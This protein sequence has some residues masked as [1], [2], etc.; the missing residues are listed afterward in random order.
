MAANSYVIQPPQEKPSNRQPKVV[1][2]MIGIN[3]CNSAYIR[4]IRFKFRVVCIRTG[5]ILM[6]IF[7]LVGSVLHHACAGSHQL[8]FKR[9]GLPSFISDFYLCDKACHYQAG[10][11][12]ELNLCHF[13]ASI[14][15]KPTD[16]NALFAIM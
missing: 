7:F 11:R 5:L 3:M 6:E 10:L 1:G 12:G 16:L 14:L 8:V 15:K 4:L 2:W 13:W 9:K